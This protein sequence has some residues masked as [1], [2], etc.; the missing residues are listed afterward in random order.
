MAN[1]SRIKNLTDN[2]PGGITGLSGYYM[3][4]DKNGDTNARKKP[5]T[6]LT[7]VIEDKADESDV[8]T[9]TNTTSYT[10]SSNYH[11]ATKKSSEDY[12]NSGGSR[13][14]KTTVNHSGA[15]N[16][17]SPTVLYA[18]KGAGQIYLHGVYRQDAVIS[19]GVTIF[20]LPSNF[21]TFNTTTS[22]WDGAGN[23]FYAESGTRSI[24][25]GS[26]NNSDNTAGFCVV[27][28]A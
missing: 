2:A 3:V 6:D 11:P 26:D 28:D 25:K 14:D 16:I 1:N 8:L 18:R 10:P 13:I 4:L 22:F 27:V 17:Q 23:N 7:S 9:K 12:V 15:T 19:S 24:K 5:I 20:T 21:P